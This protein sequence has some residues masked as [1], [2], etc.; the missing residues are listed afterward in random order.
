MEPEK[1][2][3]IRP[4]GKVEKTYSPET[5]EDNPIPMPVVASEV[6]GEKINTAGGKGSVIDALG[7]IS[8]KNF[9][10]D[11]IESYGNSRTTTS[12]DFVDLA[13]TTLNFHTDRKTRVLFLC[14]ASAGAS[15]WANEGIIRV[16]IGLNVDGT[17]YPNPTY[18]FNVVLYWHDTSDA[19]FTRVRPHWY[20]ST[21]VTVPAG[22]H[23]AKLQFHRHLLD[24][25]T[26]EVVDTSLTYIILGK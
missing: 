12:T 26:A 14:S 4:E 18:G 19:G 9:L 25:L 1:V 22:D 16:T 17:V 10:I 2:E 7:L 11:S 20:G 15:N 8:V 23:T 24:N 21:I 5:I 6:V 3:G 13:D